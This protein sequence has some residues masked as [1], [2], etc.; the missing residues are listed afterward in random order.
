MERLK[1]ELA[2]KK[3]NLV[4]LWGP[5]GA[6]KT[7]LAAEAARALADSFQHRLA[8]V[9]PLL[10]AD[11]TLTFTTLLDEIASQLGD[12][13]LRKLESEE[14]ESKVREL[15]AS[16]PALIV[17]DNFETIKSEEQSRCI[18][19]LAQ[20]ASCPAL[21]TTR[22]RID[23]ATNIPLA[24]MSV[25]EAREFLGR[26]I[27]QTRAPSKFDRL[28]RDDLIRTCEANPV[29][30]QWV[31]GQVD[32]A[33]PLR[34]V[35]SYLAQGKGDAAKRVFDRSFDSRE[36]GKD[37]R[38][39]LLALSLFVPSAS[40]EALAEVAG[41]T[42]DLARLDQAIRRLSALWLI[43][44]TDDGE[45]LMI[46]GLTREFASVQLRGS[47]RASRCRERFVNYFS[48]FTNAHA[49]ATPKDFQTLESEKEN[50]LNAIDLAVEIEAWESVKQIRWALEEFLDVYGYWEDAIRSGKQAI[51][52]VSEMKDEGAAGAFANNVAVIY[53]RRGDTKEARLLYNRSLEIKKKLGDEKGIAVTLHE[54]G[55]L[56]QN[57]GELEEAR[58]FYSQSLE[59]ARRLGNQQ[60]IASTLHELGRLAH[61]QGELETAR[62]LFEESLEIQKKLEPQSG[63]AISLYELARLAHSQRNLEKAQQLYNDSLKIAQELNDQSGIASVLLSLGWLAQI[64]D[65]LTEARRLYNES[66]EIAKKLGEQSG[67][68]LALHALGSV[69]QAHGEFTEAR[70]LYTESL[71]IEKRLGNQNGTAI[72]LS[73]LGGLAEVEGDKIEAAQRFGEA[74]AIFDRLKSR[75]AQDTR[76]SLERVK[77][78]SS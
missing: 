76:R 73:D 52:A 51:R 54:L 6:G 71:E 20:R 69:A 68:G 49:S 42:R 31:V 15:I 29:V 39:V 61:Y 22:T 65:K 1:E 4:A 63:I 44:T 21:V 30:L 40:R 13:G 17:L 46:Q 14:K 24:A 38:A 34:T 33:L 3:N 32:L 60:N 28:N 35:L 78:K 2:P 47:K 59:I 62:R 26:L 48:I 67:I 66:L 19:F 43:E 25:E 10:H 11:L 12:A 16:A 50:V 58:E 8:W 55:R 36:V 72:T 45:R 77:G 37:G 64:Q 5:G 74:L 23:G 53:E 75:K 70:R 9:S 7:T 18:S 56:A 41:L 27:E 57:H